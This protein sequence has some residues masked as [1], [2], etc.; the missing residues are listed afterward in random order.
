[1][2]TYTNIT[3]AKTI[4]NPPTI[5]QHWCDNNHTEC[6]N[7]LTHLDSQ[8]PPFSPW[9]AAGAP[10]R[11]LDT[12]FPPLQCMLNGNEKRDRSDQTKA[13][14]SLQKK[15]WT[16]IDS[17]YKIKINF[18]GIFSQTTLCK[19]QTQL[20][21]G[22]FRKLGMKRWP[23]WKKIGPLLFLPNC[24]W[25]ASKTCHNYTN[26]DQESESEPCWIPSAIST[27]RRTSHNGCEISYSLISILLI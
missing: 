10:L 8:I 21:D 27:S 7:K 9:R 25:S 4:C 11:T 17:I 26:Y 13:K 12:P 6:R 16:K 5:P 22:S 19:N 24:L 18:F 14:Y 20:D 23:R 2:C 15:T 3:Y 1:M